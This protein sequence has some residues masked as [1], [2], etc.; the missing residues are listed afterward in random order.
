MD[1]PS[2]CQKRAS[3]AIY[4][5]ASRN[6][7]L[8]KQHAASMQFADSLS[9]SFAHLIYLVLPIMGLLLHMVFDYT[10]KALILDLLHVLGLP[11]SKAG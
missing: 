2:L 5:L 4:A 11:L 3:R 7:W 10:Q 8:L 6:H 9:C 1:A